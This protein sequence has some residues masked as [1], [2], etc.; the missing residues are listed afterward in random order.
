MVPADSSG[1]LLVASGVPPKLSIPPPQKGCP[2][3]PGPHQ[4]SPPPPGV[5]PEAAEGLWEE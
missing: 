1:W 4:Q 5:R 2:G 3:A